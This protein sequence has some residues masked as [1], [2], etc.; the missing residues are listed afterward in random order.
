MNTQQQSLLMARSAQ[1]FITLLL[2]GTRHDYICSHQ[3]NANQW[4]CLV[5]LSFVAGPQRQLKF[6]WNPPTPPMPSYPCP[7][8]EVPATLR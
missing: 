1:V 3:G 4:A 6:T 2:D 8:T 7:H 5:D